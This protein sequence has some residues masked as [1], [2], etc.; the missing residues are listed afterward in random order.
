VE[1][2]AV[3]EGAE[4]LVAFL[5]HGYAV[6]VLRVACRPELEG[7]ED[8]LF[9][10]GKADPDLALA[11]LAAPSLSRAG[12][13]AGLRLFLESEGRGGA[14]EGEMRV[15]VGVPVASQEGGCTLLHP[16]GN[17]QCEVIYE[18]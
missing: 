14:V 2:I 5:Q 6:P 4:A 15:A 13:E 9:A 1:F 17:T 10:A 8:V 12:I 7:G 3:R 16:R 18:W 11:L